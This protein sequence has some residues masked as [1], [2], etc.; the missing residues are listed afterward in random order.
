MHTYRAKKCRGGVERVTAPI[1]PILCETDMLSMCVRR[2]LY[3]CK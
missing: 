2:I 3:I 1:Y